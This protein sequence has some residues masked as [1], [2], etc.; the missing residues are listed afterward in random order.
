MN[1]SCNELFVLCN[2]LH[3]VDALFDAFYA[4]FYASFFFL[5]MIVAMIITVSDIDMLSFFAVALSE[6]YLSFLYF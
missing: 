3:R 1:L 4:F 6:Y 5:I 2:R